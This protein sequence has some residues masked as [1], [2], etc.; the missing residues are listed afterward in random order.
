MRAVRLAILIGVASPLLAGCVFPVWWG[1]GF[2]SGSRDN[3]RDDGP[4]FIVP[5]RTTREEVLLALGEP[6]GEAPDGS[7]FS[8]GSAWTKGGGGV[9]AIVAAGGGAAGGFIGTEKA[10]FRRLL[11]RFDT[12]GTVIESRFEAETCRQTTS[13]GFV[14]SGGDRAGGNEPTPC[15]DIDATEL[16]REQQL[17]SVGSGG[18]PPA[19]Y[20]GSWCSGWT[21]NRARFVPGTVLVTDTA[22]VFLPP[23]GTYG[24]LPN[25]LR[26]PFEDVA[27]VSLAEWRTITR[28]ARRDGRRDSFIL[29]STV[30]DLVVE[31]AKHR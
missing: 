18:A 23:P 19:T 11:V 4:T 27:D 15:L 17:A 16:R 12:R 29:P 24:P 5:F 3:I 2:Y 21:T 28:V 8:Y 10:E 22:L 26:I 25:A 14:M 1:P 13:W 31:R 30:R 9:V 20:K 6:D 7:W